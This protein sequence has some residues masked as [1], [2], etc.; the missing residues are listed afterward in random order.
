MP[1]GDQ[2]QQGEV[3]LNFTKDY[4]VAYAKANGWTV[5]NGTDLASGLAALQAYKASGKTI[6]NLIIHSHG[7]KDGSQI[8]LGE[9]NVDYSYYRWRKLNPTVALMNQVLSEVEAG[10]TVVFT[11]CNAAQLLGTAMATNIRC[12]INAYMNTSLT[13]GPEGSSGTSFWFDVNRI[14]G[15]RPNWMNLQS[16]TSG[17]VITINSSGIKVK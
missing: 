6:T 2:G 5:L 8:H 1:V 12:D 9:S 15:P 16:G 10:S 14:G 7:T 17:H 13:Y 11:G 4:N 3:I